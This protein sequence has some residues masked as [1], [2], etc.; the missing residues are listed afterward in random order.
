[1]KIIY[2]NYTINEDGEIFNRYNK[3]IQP[4]DN[5]KGYLVVGL[6]YKNK[7]VTKAIHRLL[8][9][10]FIENPF[11]LSDVNH[12]DGDRRNNSLSN[13]EWLSHGDNIKHSY[14]LQNRSATGSNNA[15]CKTIEETV[16][17]ICKYLEEGIKP[18]KIRDLGFN[19]T[20]IRSIKCK[21]IWKHISKNF[22]F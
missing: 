22:T 7:R 5:G 17:Q 2:E 20:L 6:T 21:K 10:A 1:M 13:L 15:N 11:Q 19:Y 18:S 16:F 8:A 9:E 4:V 14:N 12:I 3:K